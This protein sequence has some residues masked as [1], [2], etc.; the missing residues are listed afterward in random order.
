M[1]FILSVMIKATLY[2]KTEKKRTK[3]TGYHVV[4]IIKLAVLHTY[5]TTKLHYIVSCSRGAHGLWLIA[6]RS[7]FKMTPELLIRGPRSTRE[8]LATKARRAAQQPPT[9]LGLA[10]SQ[11]PAY[12]RRT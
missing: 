10:R 5:L 1:R 11:P 12:D 7:A 3:R 8:S 2:R 6:N 9:K 4:S